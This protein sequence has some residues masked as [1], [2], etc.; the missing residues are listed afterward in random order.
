LTTQVVNTNLY[1]DPVRLHILNLLSVS[2]MSVK[3]LADELGLSQPTV[4]HHM[5]Q[6]VEGGLVKLSR[7]ETRG[8][9]IEKFYTS[10]YKSKGCECAYEG[11]G[12]VSREERVKV[13]YADVGFVMSIIA[14]GVSIWQKALESGDK[15]YFPFGTSLFVLPSDPSIIP[16]V[17]DILS[18]A[19][20][21]LREMASK[22]S[23][24]KGAKF[25][26]IITSVPYLQ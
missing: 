6:L 16:K 22:E 18:E 24:R 14:R 13:G 20:E 4:L 2:E 8:N 25:A 9:L 1:M 15:P 12:E 3:E 10:A 26:L 7:T 17:N 11:I 23:T 21:K 5:K 19:E